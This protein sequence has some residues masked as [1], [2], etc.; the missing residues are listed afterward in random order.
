L[1]GSY[2]D[3]QLADLLQYGFPINYV[4]TILPASSLR[5][6]KGAMEFPTHIED[7]LRTEL[8]YHAC[9]GLFPCPPFLSHSVTSP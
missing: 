8:A 1:L 5:N 9:I 2:P 6:H 3:V 7:F 4:S